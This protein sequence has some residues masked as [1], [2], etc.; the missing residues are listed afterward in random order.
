MEVTGHL[1]NLR[2]YPVRE[3]CRNALTVALDSLFVLRVTSRMVRGRQHSKPSPQPLLR[4][5]GQGEQLPLEVQQQLR[6]D[7]A[8]LSHPSTYLDRRNDP[9]SR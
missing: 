4:L 7:K 1:A 9:M 3:R 8:R 6:R 2:R 5:V